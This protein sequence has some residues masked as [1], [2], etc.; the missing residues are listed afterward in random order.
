MTRA[1]TLHAIYGGAFDPVHLGHLAVARAVRD[2]LDA[3]VAL[4]PT[5]DPPHRAPARAGAGDRLAMCE[6][7]LRGERDLCVDAREL[8][9]RGPSYSIDTLAELRAER[10]AD[11]A[12]AMVLGD[13]A[14]AGLAGWERWTGLFELA[15]IVVASRPQHAR[16]PAV[17]AEAV[18]PRLTTNAADLHEA[19]A[20][21][22]LRLEIAP[23][24]QSSSQ[25]RAR[26][27]AGETLAR[28]VPAAVEDYLAA[29]G[30]YRDEAT[31]TN[32]V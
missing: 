14:F 23:H 18:A 13:D 17:L 2:A 11:A 30:L 4:V 32:G 22:V 27:A 15:H 28:W 3:T 25:I 20:G 6:L 31:A 9:R 10:G 12:L 21:R 24:P 16:I 8:R 29:R 26:C 1:V 7:A 19:P 5:G